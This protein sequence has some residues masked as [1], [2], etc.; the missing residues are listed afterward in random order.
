MFAMTTGRT[1]IR[2]FSLII[3]LFWAVG[4]VAQGQ[5]PAG[6]KGTA[7][8]FSAPKSD[9]VSSNLNELRAPNSP[10]RAMES[11]LKKP[12][13][14]FNPDR[15]AD[16]RAPVQ[17]GVVPAGRPE[18]RKKSLKETLNDRAEAM[19]LEPELYEGETDADLFGLTAESYDP[20]EKKNKSSLDRYYDRMD[21]AAT[22][23]IAPPESAA[24][25]D[26]NSSFAPRGLN[27]LRETGAGFEQG[28]LGGNNERSAMPGSSL[29]DPVRAARDNSFTSQTYLNQAERGSSFPRANRYSGFRQSDETRLD[30][31]K[32]LLKG[33][34]ATGLENPLT[35]TATPTTSYN[36][37]PITPAPSVTTVAPRA[38]AF[39][40]NSS[41][42]TFADRANLIGTPAQPQ[43]VP[44]Y[45]T[46]TAN[47]A[48]AAPR[49]KSIE[50]PKFNVPTRRF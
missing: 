10:F 13:E 30:A 22:N 33:S 37:A 24:T 34:S 16:V 40:G 9:T 5:A 42:D 2:F 1:P 20:Y 15:A 6:Q 38:N 32:R 41:A 45:T 47:S 7:I 17:R 3:T 29:N 8:I 23:R 21:R 11:T 48:T 18:M 19:F 50:P 26:F 36:P 43:G 27:A 35:P 39:S 28:N 25:T 12:F 49:V 4:A 31:Y 46:T 44:D 14:V